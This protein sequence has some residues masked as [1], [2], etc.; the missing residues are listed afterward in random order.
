MSRLHCKLRLSRPPFSL[1]VETQFESE[2]TAIAG[3]SGA[4][5][6]TWLAALLGSIPIERG[7]ITLDDRELTKLPMHAR[8]IG[9]V[10]QQGALFPHLTV[11]RNVAFSASI[12]Q[13]RRWLERVG[14]AELAERRCDQLSGGERQRVALARALAAEPQALLLDEPFS[15]LDRQARSE[16]NRL[17]RTLQEERP[18]PCLYVSHDPIDILQVAQRRVTLEAGRIVADERAQEFDTILDAERQLFRARIVEHHP[19]SG[20]SEIDYQGTRLQ[21]SPVD[22][23]PGN[24]AVFALRPSDPIITLGESG[25]TSARNRLRGT[26]RQLDDASGRVTLTVETPAPI[27]V[28][29]T[30]DAVASLELAVGRAVELLIKASAIRNVAQ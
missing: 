26:I 1:E 29:V 19:S 17:L 7:A 11:E 5:K 6:S 20:F 18:L 10:F 30:P 4:G 2:I 23:E 13:A 9:M 22:L 27:R 12:D 16:L 28:R 25:P 15:A 24:E 8:R 3:D 21:C 14:A